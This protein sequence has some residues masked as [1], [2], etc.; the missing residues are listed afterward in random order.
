MLRRDCGSGPVSSSGDHEYYISTPPFSAS[1]FASEVHEKEDVDAPAVKQEDEGKDEKPE[2]KEELRKG[3]KREST[4]KA[5]PFEK[6]EK[7]E[8]GTL[9]GNSSTLS[10]KSDG[11]DVVELLI[12]PIHGKSNSRDASQEHVASTPIMGHRPPKR[13]R[14]I[15]EI[16]IPTWAQLQDYKKNLKKLEDMNNPNVQK[17]QDMEFDLDTVMSRLRPIGLEIFPIDLPPDVLEFTVSRKFMSTTYGGNSQA[18]FPTIKPQH[19]ARHGL[20]NWAY[21]H[22]KY[23]PFAPEIPGAPG[24]FICCAHTK[25]YSNIK[26]VLTRIKS[27]QWLPVGDY[28][29]DKS[30]RPF[31]TVA[32]WARQKDVVRKTWAR[33]MCRKKWGIAVLVRILG[34]KRFGRE[35][36]EAE[37]ADI[38][39]RKLYKNAVNPQEVEKAYLTGKEKMGV[40]TLKCVDY[41]KSFQQELCDTFPGWIPPA[42]QNNKKKKARKTGM[43]KRTATA[44]TAQPHT[45][46]RKR[47]LPESDVSESDSPISD[48][49]GE[50]DEEA[51]ES[52]ED[53][54]MRWVLHRNRSTKSRPIIL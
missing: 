8:D 7:N 6:V 51:V 48:E 11:D 36:T 32:E 28:K 39:T 44:T 12:N 20:E 49:E 16:L 33:E 38:R 10:C 22:P 50:A 42:P 47:K 15:A 13:R 31:L 46:G 40:W 17:V 1:H 35:P 45:R 23:Q 27:N 37:Q 18:T 4:R 9:V 26:R 25:D 19:L 29:F 14:L 5:Q 21:L 30:V 41:D 52:S 24:L 2:I 53:E 3:P 43:K 54:E 34:R